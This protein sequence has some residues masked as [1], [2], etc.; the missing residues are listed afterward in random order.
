MGT[1]TNSGNKTFL[2]IGF[3]KIRQKY[4]DNKEKVS[5]VTDNA[6][7]RIINDKESWAIEKDF[8]EGII[9]NIYLKEDKE[10]GNSFEVSIADG[11]TKYQLSVKENSRY[12]VDFAK[13]LPNINFSETVKLT[14]YDFEDSNNKRKVGISVMQ[15]NKKIL[16]YYT[17]KKD[18]KVFSI[19]G[20]PSGKD[21]NFK[22][23][24]DLQ[25]YLIDVKKFLR[26]EFKNKI[27]PLFS[28]ETLPENKDNT[29]EKDDLPF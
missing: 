3:G 28:N 22:D 16:S 13:K 14:T 7:K 25:I 9:E 24:D 12:W 10:Y 21:V 27:E 15:G 4:L 29:E 26:K 8:V 2:S 18:D 6:V 20:F 1:G 19:N 23:K 17:D 11:I 5:S